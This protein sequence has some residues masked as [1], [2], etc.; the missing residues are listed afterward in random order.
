MALHHQQLVE[1]K[2]QLDIKVQHLEVTNQH[3]SILKQKYEHELAQFKQ[4]KL[5]QKNQHLTVKQIHLW[6]GA[7][8]EDIAAAN[9]ELER[10][11]IGKTDAATQ[12]ATVNKLK[13]R[14]LLDHLPILRIAHEPILT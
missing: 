5:S 12:K 13:R 9:L 10:L 2:Q 1:D 3:L 14:P 6:D 8:E 11:N 7:V 4:H